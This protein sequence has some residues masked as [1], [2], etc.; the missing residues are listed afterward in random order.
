MFPQPRKSLMT[1]SYPI[2]KT[3]HQIIL[4]NAQKVQQ[5]QNELNA[6]YTLILA[7]H[8]VTV[9]TVT[10]VTDTEIVVETPDL[11]EPPEG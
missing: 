5:A 1:T 8:D 11:P 10:K 7:G 6:V 4:A 9:G 2:S 3:Q